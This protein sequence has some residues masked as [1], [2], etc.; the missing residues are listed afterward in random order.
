MSFYNKL[1]HYF[2]GLRKRHMYAVHGGDYSGGFLIPISENHIEGNYAV[3]FIP[4]PMK[5][6]YVSE[7]EIRMSLADNTLRLAGRLPDNVYEICRADFELRATQQGNYVS[8]K[9]HYRRD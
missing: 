8:K 9:S 5:A 2:F 3:L 4:S 1:Y 7:T 6:M